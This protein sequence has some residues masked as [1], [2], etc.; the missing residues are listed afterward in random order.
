M[1]TEPIS[2]RIAR[3]K[4]CTPLACEGKKYGG[5]CGGEWVCGCDDEDHNDD[6]AHLPDYLTPAA[7]FALLAEL[8]EANAMPWVRRDSIW[9]YD[10]G[11]PG[12]GI[13]GD[14]PTLA[15]AI[16]LAWLEW[17]TDKPD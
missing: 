7:S 8:V 17:H 13:S 14:A 6:S 10:F 16:A 4:G 15:E 1:E 9:C 11:V 3:A 2:T 5:T 12:T